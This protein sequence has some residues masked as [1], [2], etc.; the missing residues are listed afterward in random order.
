MN[1]VSIHIVLDIPHADAW[2]KLQDFAQAHRYVP[3]IVN[4]IITTTNK[5]GVGASRNVYQ[6]RGGYLQ[7]T[8]TEWLEG[9][10]FT[11]RLHKADKDF[12][13][14]NAFFRYEL[15]DAGKQ[16]TQFIATM[17]YEL[18]FGI[19]G[20]YFNRYVMSKII[21]KVIQEVAVS[22][23]YYYE[24]GITASKPTLKA[25]RLKLLSENALVTK[26]D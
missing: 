13:F 18:P 14:K 9:R 16:Q 6:K 1:S 17:G 21:G 25:L 3:G 11:I 22:M 4:T 24:T 20:N 26:F 12:P 10:G 8:V 19:V 23:K 15:L 7:E 5:N 2:S